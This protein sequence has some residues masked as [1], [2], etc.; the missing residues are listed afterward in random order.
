M[1]VDPN[2]KRRSI[3]SLAWLGD[4]LY[5][6]EIRRR[7]LALG[8]FHP[9]ELNKMGAN[10]ARAETQAEILTTILDKLNDEERNVAQRGK[11]AS[12]RSGGRA[13]RNTKDY[14]LASGLEALVAHWH[15]SECGAQRMTDILA[16]ELQSRAVAQVEAMRGGPSK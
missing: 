11:N 13:V 9:R 2:L 15:L 10:L 1:S 5:E 16:P 8:D 6:L 14:R 12:I 7:L 4:A 3:K